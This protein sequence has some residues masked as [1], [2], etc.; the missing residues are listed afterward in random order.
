MRK[1]LLSVSILAF[2]AIGSCS[3][4]DN[5]G[6]NNEPPLNQPGDGDN[7]VDEPNPLVGKW[8]PEN[9]R[10]TAMGSEMANL[11]YPHAEGC[12]EDYLVFEK[13]KDASFTYHDEACKATSQKEKWS[14]DKDILKFNLLGSDIEVKVIENTATKLVISGNGKQ[15]EN[16]IPI[17]LPDAEIPPLLL[18]TAVVELS[19]KKQ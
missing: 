9:A 8:I 3:S 16:L 1:I 10:V 14:Q 17:F 15:F 18:A 13:N 12:D 7:K 4:D 11:G 5:S 19:L 6:P 2:L